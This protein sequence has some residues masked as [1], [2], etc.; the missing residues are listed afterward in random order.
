VTQEVAVRK[1]FHANTVSTAQGFSMM[2]PPTPVITPAQVMRLTPY[3]VSVI[4]VSA[5]TVSVPP[6]APGKRPDAPP[7]WLVLF[8][9]THCAWHVLS[10]IIVF[11][12]FIVSYPNTTVE[13]TVQSQ[14]SILRAQFNAT[15]RYEYTIIRGF[16]FNLPGS[17]TLPVATIKA[18]L[19]TDAVVEPNSVVSIDQG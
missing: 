19:S 12:S 9:Q 16:S 14:E 4:P 8:R 11:N 6:P 17:S 5:K 3:A 1:A 10:F 15:I 18:K 13:S 2:A 7:R